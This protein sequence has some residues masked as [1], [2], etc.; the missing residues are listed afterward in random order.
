MKVGTICLDLRSETIEVLFGRLE[1]DWGDTLA[2]SHR[3]EQLTP[4]YNGLCALLRECKCHLE[5]VVGRVLAQ[6]LENDAFGCGDFDEDVLHRI[7][8]SVRP[9][10]D[11]APYTTRTEVE[12]LERVGEA[13][14]TPPP[15][16]VGGITEGAEHSLAR[17]ADHPGADDLSVFD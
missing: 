3:L 17:C 2:L 6:V 13:L 5:R 15:G 7:I 8:G 14:R 9:M 12:L 1:N 10:H 4:A 16:Q 11:E